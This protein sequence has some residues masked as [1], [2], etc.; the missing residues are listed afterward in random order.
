MVAVVRA[1]RVANGC[2]NSVDIGFGVIVF[3]V[4]IYSAIAYTQ[5]DHVLEEVIVTAQRIEQLAQDVPISMVVIENRNLVDANVFSFEDTIA[6][7]PGISVQA[8]LQSAAIRIRG[9]GERGFAVGAQSVQIYVDEVARFQPGSI[10]STLVD[11]DQIELLRGPQGTLYGANAVGGA[12]NITTR[13]PD[14]DGLSG[15][16]GTSYS[17]YA[18]DSGMDTTD[19]RGAIN[20]PL[21]SDKLALRVAGG[22]ADSSGFIAV[23]NPISADGMAGGFQHKVVRPRLLWVIN[24]EQDITYSYYYKDLEENPLR[25]NYDGL[26]PGTGSSNPFPAT[27]TQFEDRDSYA[28][29]V[30]TVKGSYDQHTVHYRGS[31]D[32]TQISLI[33]SYSDWDT[34]SNENREPYPGGSSLFQIG[35]SVDAD[36]VEL[37][38]FDT[39]DTLDYVA[40]LYHEERRSQSSLAVRVG[41]IDISGA[42]DNRAEARAAYAN[43]NFH[44]SS[45]WDFALGGRY[46]E[47]DTDLDTSIA[48]LDFAGS[49]QEPK[50]Y[51]NWSWSIKLLHLI[52]DNMTAYLAVDNAYKPGA[53][54]ILVAAATAPSFEQNFPAAYEE[55]QRALFYDPEESTAYEIGLK[56]IA[57]NN[58]LQYSAAIFYQEFDDHQI[59]QSDTGGIALLPVDALFARAKDNAEGVETKGVELELKYLL[60]EYWDVSVSV[61]YADPTA[62]EWST[63]YC[64]RGEEETPDQLYCPLDGDPLSEFPKWTSYNELGYRAPLAAGHIF[65]HVNWAWQSEP[66]FTAVTDEYSEDKHS[67]GFNLGYS[68]QSGVT[69]QVWGKN[70]TDEHYSTSPV[71]KA[72]GDPM[73]PPAF[74]GPFDP[75]REYGVTLNYIF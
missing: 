44:I 12:Y 75:G 25:F 45:A 48:F 55:A 21:I 32:F 1:S 18:K 66:N 70:L 68:H 3:I 61:A 60:A 71:L 65:A 39:G 34:Q 28:E 29:F 17:R 31:F 42:G 4:S 59:N 7:T 2:K 64:E 53:V 46:D 11:I 52:S 56:G 72:N 24:E 36:I 35:T 67:L 9:V 23:E 30:S 54:N 26:V 16:V 5:E 19:I 74:E 8:G 58:R 69:V 50:D 51:D 15:H 33:Y 62:N 73:Q 49:V 14:L 38:L 6:L 10:F 41:T 43:V 20:I 22:Y 27:S 47:V 57:L 13:R 40:G 37:R 63:R